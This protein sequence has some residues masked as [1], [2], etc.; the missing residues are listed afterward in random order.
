MPKR[1]TKSVDVRVK[2]DEAGRITGYASTFTREPDWVGDI[3]A[4]GAF[5]ESLERIRA[6]GAVLPLLYNHDQSLDSFIG[7][8]D[9]IEEDD[10]GLLFS[11][12]FDQTESAQRARELAM[13][14][15]LAK[16][17]F[18]YA[19]LDQ[20][21]V[22][23]PDGRKAN[24]LR[25]L[26]ID[27][28]SLVLTPANPDTSVV[29]VKAGRRNS[30]GDEDTIRQAIGLLQSLLDDGQGA[31]GG[32]SEGGEGDATPKGREDE[33]ASAIESAK[34]VAAAVMA[35]TEILNQ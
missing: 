29:E 6:E 7:R 20:C 32:D 14:G 30:K 34:E 35:A 19:I 1:N 31:D 11:A 21:E 25:K 24:E 12:S 33:P 28:V 3:V 2:A 18:A 16:F 8:V 27:E 9:S 22:E 4:K 10:H 23:L 17:S 26:D 13:D 15:R 5:A